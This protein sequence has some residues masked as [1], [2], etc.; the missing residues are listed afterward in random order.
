MKLL[1][2]EMISSVCG[3]APGW[4][5]SGDNLAIETSIQF[6]DFASAWS[7]MSEIALHAER[8]NHHPEWSNVYGCVNLRLTT[9]DAGGLTER[10][11][12]LAT[13]ISSALS[14]RRWRP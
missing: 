2:S 4:R 3:Q 13:I 11:S 1:D 12:E 9:H 14:Q 10:D 6:E 5:L 8:L 7:F